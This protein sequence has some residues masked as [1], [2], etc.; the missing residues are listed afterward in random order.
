MIGTTG[1]LLKSDSIKPGMDVIMAGTLAIGGTSVIAERYKDKLAGKF[2]G[3]FISECLEL[4]D[5]TSTEKAS[6]IA[7]DEGAVYM[8]AV[9]EGG[10]FSGLWE[11]ASCVDKGIQVDINKIPI[12]Q[13]VIEIAEFMDINPYL[14]E[15]SGSLLIVSPDGYKIEESLNANGIYGEVI[16]KI[17]DNKNRV[18]INGD[19]TRYLE[20]PRGDEIYKFI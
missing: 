12:W 17:T 18:V 20:P 9:S 4:K 19:E 1:N 6:A 2:S 3:R 15:G 8:H 11:V 16:G 10:L 7:I 5:Y 14:L 13:Q